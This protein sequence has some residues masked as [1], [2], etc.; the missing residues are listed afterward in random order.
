M[1]AHTVFFTLS[2]GLG[3]VAAS[4]WPNIRDH[5]PKDLSTIQAKV[6]LVCVAISPVSMMLSGM[7]YLQHLMGG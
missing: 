7:T 6:F 4:T 5:E 1:Q 2:I 3:L